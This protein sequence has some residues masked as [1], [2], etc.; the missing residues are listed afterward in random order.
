MNLQV[1][2][3]G[4]V[5]DN[6]V[7]VSSFVVSSSVASFIAPAAV[8]NTRFNELHFTKSTPKYDKATYV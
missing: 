4:S 8:C 1:A 7:C 5:N 6:F 2:Q 3:V